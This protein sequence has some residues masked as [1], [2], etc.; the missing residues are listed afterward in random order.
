M[1]DFRSREAIAAD[2]RDAR[3]RGDTKGMSRFQN[4]EA[5]LVLLSVLEVLA[6]DEDSFV[7][8]VAIKGG[9]L[10]AGE[11]RSPRASA[12]IDAT[13]GDQMRVDV[14]RVAREI[15]RAGREF[16]MRLDSEPERTTGGDTIHLAFDSLT[17][18]GIAKFEISVREDL[19][20]NVR[21]AIIDLTE[22]GLAV[23]TVPAVAK[24]EL[25][26]EK[27]RCLVQRAQPRDLFAL[28]LYLV[29]SDW[30]FDPRELRQAVEAKLATTR[31]KRWSSDAWRVHLEEIEPLWEPTLLEWVSP[32][33]LP[34]FEDA[35]RDVEGRLRQLG[36][37]LPLRGAVT[38]GSPLTPRTRQGDRPAHPLGG[39]GPSGAPTQGGRRRAPP[40]ARRATTA[41]CR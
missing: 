35:V 37:G 13:S 12:D 31:L 14:D 34:S 32:D 6:Q 1:P 24:V 39:S 15:V 16:A 18:R 38:F 8:T 36:L 25:V 41:A 23:F 2:Y 26:A 20:F 30:Q 19:V 33:H 3:G 9:I 29:D 5:C 11:L 7:H 17:D 10:M 28:R 4:E 22:I 27:L 40:V 21:D